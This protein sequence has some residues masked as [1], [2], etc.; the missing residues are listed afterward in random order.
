MTGPAQD[1]ILERL[2]GGEILLAEGAMG[3]EQQERGLEQGDCGEEWNIGRPDR[4]REIHRS[5]AEAGADIIYTNTFGATELRLAEHRV[6]GRLEDLRE[7]GIDPDDLREVTRRVNLHGARLACEVSEDGARFVA[8]DLGPAVGDKLI[9]GVFTEEE[10]FATYRDQALFLKE[11]GVNLFAIET[12]FDPQ[13]STLAYR[14][15]E[16]LGLPVLVS[17]AITRR[18]HLGRPATDFGILVEKIPELY[19]NADIV[20]INCG[21]DIDLTLEAVGALRDLTDKPILAKPN[22]GIPEYVKG[23]IFYS[24]TP[25]D[26]AAYAKR[27]AEAGANIIG[28]CCGTTPDHIAAM[29][30]VVSTSNERAGLTESS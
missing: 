14:A 17:L 22:A 13:E 7:H 5:Y 29:R 26:L 23:K 25:D 2:T 3:T 30:A 21:Q 6:K 16:D 28:G 9:N 8:G 18:S 27:F 20:G 10:V 11:G 15:V 19:P 4:V 1:G 12:V 24:L